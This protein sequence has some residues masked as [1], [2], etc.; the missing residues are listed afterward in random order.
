MAPSGFRSVRRSSK[1]NAKV[2]APLHASKLTLM[3]FGSWRTLAL[4]SWTRKCAVSRDHTFLPLRL[5]GQPLGVPSLSP[6]ELSSFLRR[7]A[8]RATSAHR[9]RRVPSR[10]SAHG[11]LRSVEQRQTV[12]ENLDA[13][14]VQ[15]VRRDCPCP[16]IRL[17][18]VTLPLPQR[19]TR[20]APDS[21]ANPRLPSTPP[22]HMLNG[23]SLYCQAPPHTL[24]D[25]SSR[26]IQHAT[27]SKVPT[28]S[29]CKILKDCQVLD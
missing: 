17:L 9:G 6:G 12:D 25:A 22:R 19:H 8:S 15:L 26:N 11:H 29:R 7:A 4:V 10:R 18:V 23:V 20:A 2:W 14:F 5:P 21:A 27:S 24:L 16:W 13:T 1:E 3:T 28:R